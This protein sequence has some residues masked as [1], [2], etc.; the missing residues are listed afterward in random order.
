MGSDE[1]NEVCSPGG[2]S[3]PV[4]LTCW[5]LLTA[6]RSKKVYLAKLERTPN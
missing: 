4:A 3:L 1:Q 5:T 6:M 2:K